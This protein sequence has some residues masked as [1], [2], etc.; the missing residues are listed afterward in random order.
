[1]ATGPSPYVLGDGSAGAKKLPV[2]ESNYG[3]TATTAS[4]GP[5]KANPCATVSKTAEIHYN[6]ITAR[7]PRLCSVTW[8]GGGLS[9]RSWA[10][11]LQEV[12]QYIEG[13]YVEG[14]TFT[15]QMRNAAYETSVDRQDENTF[16]HMR[17]R[18]TR[19]IKEEMAEGVSSVF[20]V[21]LEPKHR[22]RFEKVDLDENLDITL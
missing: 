16:I 13:A 20:E 17:N 6:I 8:T 5:D 3:Q 4:Q 22:A 10:G 21:E 14:I 9:N 19:I 7:K 11:L 12:S 2:S 15:L 1:M 18:W